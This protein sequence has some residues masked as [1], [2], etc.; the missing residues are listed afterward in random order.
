MIVEI[1]H[2]PNMAP[3]YEVR[4]DLGNGYTGTVCTC[5]T[6]NEARAAAIGFQAGTRAIKNLIGLGA[7]FAGYIRVA[8]AA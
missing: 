6:E 5:D 7:Q 3:P 2:N 4:F 1:T 8:K